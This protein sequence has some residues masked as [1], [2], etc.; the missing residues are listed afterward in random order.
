[1]TDIPGIP[2]RPSAGWYLDPDVRMV[3]RRWDG[4]RWTEP[5]RASR[6]SSRSLCGP[7][8]RPIRIHLNGCQLI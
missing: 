8:T 3:L 7:V 2:E 1:M 6:A 4:A 5:T